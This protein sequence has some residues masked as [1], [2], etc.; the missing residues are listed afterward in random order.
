M[1]VQLDEKENNICILSLNIERKNSCQ[2]YEILE[3]SINL[4]YLK[5]ETLKYLMKKDKERKTEGQYNREL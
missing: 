4:N 5:C 1:R 2:K 3:T